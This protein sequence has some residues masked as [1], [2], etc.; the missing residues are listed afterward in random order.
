MCRKCDNGIIRSTSSVPYQEGEAKIE[1]E[2]YCDCEAGLKLA[3][4][5]SADAMLAPLEWRFSS[6]LLDIDDFKLNI[7]KAQRQLDELKESLNR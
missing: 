3:W 5:E 7:E 2:D 6:L 1:H 4:I